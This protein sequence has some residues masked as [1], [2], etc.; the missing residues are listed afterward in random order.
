MLDLL[1]S[2]LS[3]KNPKPLSNKGGILVEFAIGAPILIT[4]MLYG[5]DIFKLARIKERI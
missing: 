2:I 3:R 5:Y 4:V 1:K